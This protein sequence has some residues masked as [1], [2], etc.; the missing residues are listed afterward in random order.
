MTDVATLAATVAHAHAD[1]TALR[2]RG[3]DS[4]RQ[5]LGRQ[6][7]GETLS[8]EDLTGIVDYE[9]GELVIS[10]RAGTPVADIDAVLATEN[11][12]LPSSTPAFDG[13]ATVGGS[14]ACNLSG[15]TRPW[16]GSIRDLVLGTEV[17]NG[18][19]EV[20]RFGG[21]VMKNV[22]GYD[23]S[24]LQCGA[25][26]TLGVITEVTLKVLPLPE[27]ETTLVYECDAANGLERMIKHAREASP[28]AGACWFDGRLYLR[29][30]GAQPAVARATRDWGGDIVT[31]GQPW[32]LLSDMS[33]DFFRRDLP[34]IRL[35][36]PVTSQ[37][38]LEE[39]P[40][41]I[42]WGGAQRWVYADN[43]A[44]WF[45][46]AAREGGHAWSFRGGDRFAETAPSLTA[47][48]QSMHQRVK[49][50]LDPAGILNPGRLYS[51]M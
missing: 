3:G 19:G 7:D 37:L 20:L 47:P 8:T 48:V 39:S 18:K 42:N 26:G 11:Q 30:A 31:E 17:I 50:A 45:D 9:P 41:L 34:L 28:M 14:V 25:L 35:S 49:Q 21:R 46:L 12:Y 24:R 4:K 29:L 38:G 6:C 40:L 27:T 51:W 13:K 10:A 23:V 1:R 32:Q 15:H 16:G 36:L 33:L 43:D 22:A 2:I 44:S 5:L